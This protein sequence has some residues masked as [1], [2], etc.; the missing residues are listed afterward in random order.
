MCRVSQTLVAALCLTGLV[1]G[2]P[3]ISIA[4]GHAQQSD[5][6]PNLD[7]FAQT[8]AADAAVADAALDQLADSWRD[9]YVGLLRDLM[10][11]MTAPTRETRSVDSALGQDSA[12]DAGLDQ[13]RPGDDSQQAA[14][15]DPSTAIW[16]RLGLFLEDRTGVRLRDDQDMF[17]LNE[18]LWA[19]PYDPHPDYAAFK[20]LLYSQIDPRFRDFFVADTQATIRLDEIGWGGVPVNGIPPLAFPRT[21]GPDDDLAA[22]LDDDDVV[23]GVEVDGLTRAYPKRILAWHE[24]A[25]DRVG[26]VDLTV[27]YCTL[28]G[29]V[30]PY[31]SVVNG[32]RIIFG[33]SGLLY[34]SNKLM[35]DIETNSLWNTFEG[36]PVVG[37]RVGSGIRLVHRPVVTTTW[38][39]WRRTHPDTS[40]LTMQT[41]QE[42]DYSEGAAYR[43][44]FAT[45]RLMFG[46][47]RLDDRLNNKDEVLVLSRA[48][49]SGVRQ[50]VALSADF[51]DED[52]HRIHHFD[53][54]GQSLVVVTSD[55]G[56]NRVYDSADLRFERQRGDDRI[57]DAD[58]GEWSVREDALVFED[59]PTRRLERQPAHRAFWFAWYAQFPDTELVH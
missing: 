30:I 38:G 17:D 10:R 32:E 56:A 37:S 12:D 28:C 55:E 59:D 8:A 36:V 29:T 40:V 49:G 20:A 18:W 3:G 11:L 35:F 41:G 52:D 31:E 5:A 45:D 26:D 42:R 25:I 44:Y 53:H 46:V 51:L 54:A 14:S 9:G 6:A 57:V 19:Q 33:T 50:H 27:V 7:L 15:E 58:G 13:Q 16:R 47:P 4:V 34:R 48:D 22:Y 39:E 21:V 2:V 43:G 23:F 24:M 1:G